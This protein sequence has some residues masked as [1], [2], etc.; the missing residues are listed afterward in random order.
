MCG[1]GYCRRLAASPERRPCAI[2]LLNR[3]NC[4][5]NGRISQGTDVSANPEFGFKTGPAAQQQTPC[6][7]HSRAVGNDRESAVKAKL[8]RLSRTRSQK[9]G[10]WKLVWL[11]TPRL[12]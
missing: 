7:C 9:S 1:T 12:T 5:A 2:F 6:F 3:R 4:P 11:L 10:H 8:M